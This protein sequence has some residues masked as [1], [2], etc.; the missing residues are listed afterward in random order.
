MFHYFLGIR[1]YA[2]QMDVAAK[3]PTPRARDNYQVP[4]VEYN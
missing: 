3:Y 1:I 4:G 2:H